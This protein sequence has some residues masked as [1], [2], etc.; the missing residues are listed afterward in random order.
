MRI[1]QHRLAIATA[2]LLVTAAATAGVATWTTNGPPGGGS[3]NAIADPLVPGNVY[4]GNL[5]GL[6]ILSL[7]HI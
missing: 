5:G 6:F 4:A 1:P 7:I 3:L 2:A